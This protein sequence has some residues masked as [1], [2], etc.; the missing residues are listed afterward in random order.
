M[1]TIYLIL[2]NIFHIK[3][4]KLIDQPNFDEALSS[5][6][7][8]QRWLSME[9]PTTAHLLNET[10]N[11]LWNAFDNDKKMWYKLYMVLINKK[12]ETYKKI[13]YFK[14]TK[15]IKN[16]KTEQIIETLANRNQ[17]SQRET[18]QHL[19][20]LTMLNKD[21]ERFKKYVS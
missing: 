19:A 2:K 5:N 15:K 18:E 10:T 6:Y 7:M 13:V 14:K 8:L 9:S 20:L 16:E 4:E 3:S 1:T 11:K 17:I 21:T 12:P